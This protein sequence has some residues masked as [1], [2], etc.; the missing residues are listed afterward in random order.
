[1]SEDSEIAQTP[2][3]ALL[4]GIY[5]INKEVEVDDVFLHLMENCQSYLQHKPL[6]VKMADYLAKNGKA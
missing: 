6:M 3:R 2:L 1:M 4:Y 5:E